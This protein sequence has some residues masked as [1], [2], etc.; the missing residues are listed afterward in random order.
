[1][2][3]YVISQATKEMVSGNPANTT[4]SEYWTFGRQG[5]RWVLYEIDQSVTAT[6]L[7]EMQPAARPEASMPLA[8]AANG[9]TI[10]VHE[11]PRTPPPRRL[12]R[13]DARRL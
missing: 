8:R 3:D 12:A 10:S 5:D 6:E 1:M 13:Q 2:V 11:S 4:F 7:L 9:R